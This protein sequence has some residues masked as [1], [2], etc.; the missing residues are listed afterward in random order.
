M[1]PPA[2]TDCQKENCL[3]EGSLEVWVKILRCVAGSKG[4]TPRHL[5]LESAGL[6][7]PTDHISWATL[8]YTIVKVTVPPID[9]F[10]AASESP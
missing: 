5:P 2:P 1:A 6:P 9:S 3:A 4:N 7:V 8:T 10:T